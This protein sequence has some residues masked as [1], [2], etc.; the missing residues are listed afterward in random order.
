MRFVTQ[1]KHVCISSLAN[2]VGGI[3][4][5][6]SLKAM[7]WV[8]ARR[9]VA[10]M[11]YQKRDRVFLVMQEVCGTVRNV[12]FS[13]KVDSSVSRSVFQTLPRPAFIGSAPID[14]FPETLDIFGRKRRKWSNGFRHSILPDRVSVAAGVHALAATPNRI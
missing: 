10:V 1:L 8:A 2:H 11:A 9:V 7:R 12:V 5:M 6:A 4:H 13:R 14:F 3:V